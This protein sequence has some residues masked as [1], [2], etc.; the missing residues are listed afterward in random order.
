MPESMEQIDS[1]QDQA[2]SLIVVVFRAFGYTSA[3]LSLAQLPLLKIPRWQR[4]AGSIPAVRTT[5]V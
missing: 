5:P 4:R 1:H 2:K 3:G